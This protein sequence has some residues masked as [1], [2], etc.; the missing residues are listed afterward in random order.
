MPEI[1]KTIVDPEIIRN[2]FPTL[3]LLREHAPV[4]HD[5]TIGVY[6]VT[7]YEDV[8]ALF[9][10]EEL[11]SRDRRQS[12][13]FTPPPP[14]SWA[15]RMDENGTGRATGEEHRA[16]RA[17]LSKGFT[18]RAVA[19]QEQQ[20][21][22]VVARFGDPLRGR[23]GIVDLVDTFTNPIP[24]T[25]ISRIVGIPPY[26]DEED[27]FRQL[28]QDV[29]RRFFFMADE[30]NVR[31]GEAAFD[32]LAEWVGKL[33]VERR[34]NPA[35]D[36]VS[37]L[38]HGNAEDPMTDEDIVILIAVLIAAGSETTTLGGTNAL[39]L[40]L[41]CPDQLVRLREDPSLAR[42]AVRESLRFDFGTIAGSPRF[43]S[44]DFE[45]RG[46][47]IPKGSTLMLSAAAANRDPR[48]FDDP[49]TF[50]IT[51]DNRDMLTFGSGPHYCLGANLAL[52]EMAC[53]LESAI[54]FLP[55][56]AQLLE[57]DI[58]WERI[59]LMERPVGLPVRFS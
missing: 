52:Q 15:E 45:L 54:D 30:E 40:L 47:T 18:P 22:D 38:I 42:A 48:V 14:G 43:A 19:R 51:R 28:A 41:K 11:L 3:G 4:Y 27:R 10:E 23:D 39:R 26:P 59:G 7:R 32:E 2:P 29:I 36:L 33:S 37:D 56:G 55:E 44:E 24:N 17:R 20:V 21:R 58:E 31:R 1:P 46:V 50:D 5:E 6:F 49:D 16:W 34:Q 8:K 25:V 12:P 53:M 57:D 35:E 13:G 9:A